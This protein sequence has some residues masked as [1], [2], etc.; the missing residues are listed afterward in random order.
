MED[1]I[2]H[3]S[4]RTL[5]SVAGSSSRPHAGLRS[6]VILSHIVEVALKRFGLVIL[7]RAIDLFSHLHKLASIYA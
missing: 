5:I 6:R 1:T 4:Q 3:D 7:H 2:I